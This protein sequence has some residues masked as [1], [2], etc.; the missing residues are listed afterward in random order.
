M[1]VSSSATRILIRGIV[2][3]RDVSTCCVRGY[4]RFF[5]AR[6]ARRDA[7]RYRRKGLDKTAQ[8]IVDELAR[9]RIDGAT[10]LEIGGGVGAIGLELLKLGAACVTIVELSHGYDHE[11]T[12]LAAESGFEERVERLHGDFVA[13]ESEIPV[14]DVVVLHRVVCCY[15]EPDLLVGAAARHSQR[16]LALTF[17]RDTWWIRLGWSA[18]N[19][20]LRL[21][22]Q[23]ESFVH[24]HEAILGPATGEGFTPAYEHSG[25]L[26]QLEALERR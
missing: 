11:A 5:G 16:L 12:A 6:T 23:F 3:S 24:R 9:R 1:I 17:P 19:V 7:R 13:G 10:V 18:A 8:L 25:H 21:V 26:W 14:A 4:E 20:F 15:P 2:D 22:C